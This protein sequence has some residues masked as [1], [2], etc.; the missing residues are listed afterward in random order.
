[1]C[2]WTDRRSTHHACRCEQVSASVPKGLENGAT[3]G[4]AF[5]RR[6]GIPVVRAQAAAAAAPSA[7][8]GVALDGHEVGED[9]A[10]AA[11]RLLDDD[12]AKQ[13]DLLRGTVLGGV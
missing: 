8:V 5:V 11:V 13:T 3:L 2:D 1:M 4:A 6:A 7:A 9:G 12:L 10:D